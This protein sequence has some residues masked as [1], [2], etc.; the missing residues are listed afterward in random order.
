MTIAQTDEPT[1]QKPLRLWPGVVAVVLQWL[2]WLVVPI[3]VPGAGAFGMI[4]G[5]LGGL[6]V[7]VWW[8]FFSRVPWSERLGAIVLGIVG[9]FATKSIIHVSI[10]TGAQGILLYVLVIPVLCLAFVAWAVAP[11]NLPDGPRR[12]TMA[13]TLLLGS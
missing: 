12:A 13:A 9:M 1:P 5:L 6:A 8:V 2:V 11:R 3:V 7:V 10:A 4:G